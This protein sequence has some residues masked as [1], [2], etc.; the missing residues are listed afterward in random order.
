MSIQR[1]PVN[2]LSHKALRGVIEEL[3]TRDG[4]DYAGSV[5]S[6]MKKM[7]FILRGQ[8]QGIL[9]WLELELRMGST[10][11]SQIRGRTLI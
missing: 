3:I 6:F 4:T 5:K 8:L 9:S 7:V 10:Q 11:A 1:I 2:K